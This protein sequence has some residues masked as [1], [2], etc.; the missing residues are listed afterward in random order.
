MQ[1][2]Q[3]Q[4]PPVTKREK[5]HNILCER[6]AAIVCVHNDVFT[7]PIWL[8]VL[9]F[10]LGIGAC[11][12]LVVS[13]IIPDGALHTGCLIGGLGVAAAVGLFYLIMRAVR[14]MS[15]QQ[16]TAVTP[17]GKY[18]FRSVNK[19]RAMFSDGTNTI[20][21]EKLEARLGDFWLEETRFDFFKDMNVDMRIT[22][23]DKETFVGT[24]DKGDKTVKCKIVFKDNIPV[25]G[26]VGGMRVKYFDVNDRKQKFIVP[27]ALHRAMMEAN[28][29]IPKD[30]NVTFE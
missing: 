29:P 6:A 17:D 28:I 11:A 19:N 2:T 10:V 23:G 16:Y 14:P 8:L 30:V 18:V 25:V 1:E 20:E 12:L 22:K 13:M 21:V 7:L 5:F 27:N 9:N 15:F 4:T 3:A 26:I 24:L